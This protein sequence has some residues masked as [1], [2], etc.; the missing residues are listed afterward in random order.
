MICAVFRRKSLVLFLGFPFAITNHLGDAL[1]RGIAVCRISD[2]N[3]TNPT[4]WVHGSSLPHKIYE[5]LLSPRRNKLVSDDN[6]NPNRK[7]I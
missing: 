2:T 4:S 6:G 3:R 1:F 7:K 5:K